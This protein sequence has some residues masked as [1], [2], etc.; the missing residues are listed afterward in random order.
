MCPLAMPIS[1]AW[2]SPGA[3]AFAGTLQ[4]LDASPLNS[5]NLQPGETAGASR[6]PVGQPAA[7]NAAASG[8]DAAA[9]TDKLAAATSAPTN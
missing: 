2:T 8:Y 5:A 4:H 3:A 9:S 1:K 6:L 7:G